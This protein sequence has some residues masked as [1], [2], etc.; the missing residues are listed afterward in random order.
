MIHKF[1]KRAPDFIIGPVEN[2]YLFRWYLIP[3]NRFFNIYLHKFL[4]SDDDR[5]LHDHPWWSIGMILEGEYMEHVPDLRPGWHRGKTCWD[6]NR[7]TRKIHRKAYQPVFR[8]SKAIHRVELFL[9]E[10]VFGEPGPHHTIPGLPVHLVGPVPVWT[11]FITGPK[12]RE[13]GFW[14]PKGFRPWKEFVSLRDG[15]NEVGKGCDE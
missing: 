3:K 10:Y 2:P 8:S 14:C 11:L 7:W 1:I 9:H 4:R 12:V 13:W 15:G 6:E 5:A